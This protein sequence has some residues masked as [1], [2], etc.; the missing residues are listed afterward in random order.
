MP[1]TVSY[2]DYIE[3][4]RKS[5]RK[6]RRSI[7]KF[8]REVLLRTNALRKNLFRRAF[9][10]LANKKQNLFSSRRQRY[11]RR[12]E[13]VKFR[14]IL[15]PARIFNAD[16]RHQAVHDFQFYF[17]V[18]RII[19]ARKEIIVCAYSFAGVYVRFF[20]FIIRKFRKKFRKIRA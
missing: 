13:I 12:T 9:I 20:R 1:H 16:V 4:K 7:G 15:I 11:R 3:F 8:N 14:I 19:S 5:Q 18:I 2:T 17:H 6:P 10:S